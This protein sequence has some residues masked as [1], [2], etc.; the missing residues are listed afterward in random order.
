MITLKIVIFFSK[1]TLKVFAKY[2]KTYFQKILVILYNY[3]K[4]FSVGSIKI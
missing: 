1:E 4:L 2:E 3:F